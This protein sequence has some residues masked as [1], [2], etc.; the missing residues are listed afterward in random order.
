VDHAATRSICAPSA[1]RRREPLA[2]QPARPDDDRAVRIA[3]RYLRSHRDQLV[4]EEQ[5]VLEHLLEDQHRALGLRRERDRDAREVGRERGPRAVLDLHLV[6]ACVA[7]HDELLVARD[8]AVVAVE[9]AAEPEA[10]EHEPDHPHVVRHAARDP[11]LAAGDAGERHERGDLDVVGADGVLAAAEPAHAVH[12]HDVGADP[13]DRRAHLVEHPREV[14]HVRFGGGV[15]DHRRAVDQRRRHQS[16]L[17][18]HHGRLVHEE[19]AG[20]QAA[21]VGH[22]PDV[23]TV[24]DDRAEGAERVEVGIEA[25]AADHVTA[26]RRHHG[27]AEAREQRAGGQERRPDALRELGADVRAAHLVGL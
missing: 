16:V 5:P 19:V 23:V 17:G 1:R 12:L 18:A 10:R 26:R 8:D 21:V 6:V 20:P 11:Q 14:L 24:L 3:D 15:A 9:L 22:D 4:H 27:R 7:R 2:V 25:A 13:L